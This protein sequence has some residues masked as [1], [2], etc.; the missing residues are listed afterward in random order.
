MGLSQEIVE[1][2]Y[3]V[4]DMTQGAFRAIHDSMEMNAQ[5]ADHL[6]AK[7]ENV[8]RVGQALAVGAGVVSAAL[9]F[10]A[11]Q[12]LRLAGTVEQQ[13]VAFKGLLG[14]YKEADI[15]IARIRKEAAATP[16]ETSGLT[17]MTQ[18]LS[19]I[20]RDGNKA[21]D[22]LMNIGDAIA[23]SGKDVTEMERVVLNIQ[24]VAATGKVTE[25]DIRQFQSAIPLFN[26]ILRASGLTTESLKTSSTAAADLFGAF[27]KAAAEGG[28]TFKG[29]EMQAKTLNGTLS[30]LHDNFEN[31]GRQ[32]GDGLL[33]IVQPVVTFFN[34]LLGKIGELSPRMKTF[35]AIFTVTTLAVSGIVAGFGIMLTIIPALVAGWAL[36]GTTM[37]VAL[38][39]I[40]IIIT[41]VI[42]AIA[43]VVVNLDKIKVGFANAFDDTRIT[44]NNFVYFF[45]DKMQK[46]ANKMANMPIFGKQFAAAAWYLD[47]FMSDIEDANK[48]LEKDIKARNDELAVNNKENK[49]EQG[50]GTKQQTEKEIAAAKEAAEKQK[51]YNDMIIASHEAQLKQRKDLEGEYLAYF[52][53]NQADQTEVIK[54]GANAYIDYEKRKY[55]ASLQA[56]MAEQTAI[57]AGEIA[58]VVG[59]PMGLLRLVGVGAAGALVS[60]INAIKLAQGGSMVVDSPTRIGNNVIAG[61]AGPERI[62]VTPLNKEGQFSGNQVINLSVNVGNELLARRTLKLGQAMRSERTLDDGLNFN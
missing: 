13:R 9:G 8:G 29:L 1:V 62:T 33:P 39:G 17:A 6:K 14:S 15:V 12:S 31:V 60:S 40:P 51:A 7:L 2:V 49:K 3:K 44:V 52:K 37:S 4:R 32:L 26:D 36:L 18:Q 50:N 43:T 55:M 25:L 16:F 46:L 56:W 23:M 30:T 61:E 54:I 47:A 57:A 41:A 53:A 48:K 21:V 58:S 22:I 59:I 5:K 10:M 27:K 20:T 42:A 35:L 38:L 11:A 24:Q 34:N 19:V 28:I 45:A